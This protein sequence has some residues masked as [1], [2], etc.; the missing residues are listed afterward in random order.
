MAV[1]EEEHVKTWSE[2]S[3]MVNEYFV[4]FNNYIFRGQERESWKLESTLTR[5]IHQ[6][7]Y[8]ENEQKEAIKLHLG[9]FKQN[10]RSRIPVDFNNGTVQ[11]SVSNW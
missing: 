6:A 7:G 1:I 8:Q 10:I 11:K 2:L 5:L 3:A 4:H 9:R